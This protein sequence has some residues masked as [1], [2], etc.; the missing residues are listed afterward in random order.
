MR[1]T[2]SIRA[3][4]H[5]RVRKAIQLSKPRKAMTTKELEHTGQLSTGYPP[6]IQLSRLCSCTAF[7]PVFWWLFA[8]MWGGLANGWWWFLG[9]GGAMRTHIPAAIFTPSGR[10]TWWRS[11]A[12]SAASLAL[13]DAGR[14]RQRE[15]EKQSGRARRSAQ[16]HEALTRGELAVASDPRER[17]RMNDAR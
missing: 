4:T 9:G 16:A 8:S 3:R 1:T 5:V 17:G 12:A 15:V 13:R 2:Y 10:P 7:W 6:V 14:C 11:S